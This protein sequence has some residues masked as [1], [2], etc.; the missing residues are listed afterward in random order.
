NR[1]IK[2]MSKEN[3]NVNEYKYDKTSDMPTETSLAKEKGIQKKNRLMKF[4]KLTIY[5]VAISLITVCTIFLIQHCTYL[6]T[7]YKYN[8]QPSVTRTFDTFVAYGGY[9][10]T[11]TLIKK[12]VWLK[13]DLISDEDKETLKEYLR[14]NG[15]DGFSANGRFNIYLGVKDG[16]DIVEFH[17]MYSPYKTITFDLKL[18]YKLE[19]IISEFE[20][21]SGETITKEFLN[22]RLIDAMEIDTLGIMIDFKKLDDGTYGHYY[23]AILSGKAYIINK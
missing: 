6:S 1:G 13:C 7:R 5:T 20:Q 12:E 21:L 9:G 14:S 17:H 4:L 16:K 3:Q 19:S 18:N 11:S 22:G 8:K 15:K 2:E 10:V 23:K